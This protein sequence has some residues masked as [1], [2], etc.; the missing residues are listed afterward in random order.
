MPNLRL[1]QATMNITQTSCG[2]PVRN[3]SN[4]YKSITSTFSIISGIFVIQR[5]G[6]KIYTRLDI[7]LDD[8][9]VLLALIVG[10]P[11]AVMN[12]HAVI[13]NGL[14]RDIWTLSPEQITNF[15]RFFY[16]EEIIYIADVSILKLSF[17][18]FYMRIFPGTTIR[19]LLLGT[20]AVN[21]LSGVVFTFVA[22]FQCTPISYFWEQWEQKHV[23]ACININAFG[24]SNAAF[25]IGLDLWMLALPLWQIK[26]LQLGW[27]KK[28]GVAV[29]FS[30]GTL[31]VTLPNACW[32]H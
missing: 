16:I 12:S 3:K 31:Y 10:T 7:C 15:G 5:F 30:M 8:W 22:I 6:Y 26:G 25:S 24:W 14:G 19:W 28:L 29:M 2:A 23:G 32:L 4:M 18:F 21:C 1:R 20:V 27:K 9:F 13:D 17:L 11:A